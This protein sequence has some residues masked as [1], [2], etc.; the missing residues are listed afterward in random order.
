MLVESVGSPRE[1]DQ[2]ATLRSAGGGGDFRLAATLP[3]YPAIEP[4]ELLE[5]AGRT[6]PRP[7]SDY[8]RYLER[9]GAWGTLDVRSLRV[10]PG[11]EGPGRAL[12]RIRRAAGEALAA[13]LPE[14][15]AGLAAGIMVGLRD[16]V[17]REL[18]AAF[19]TAG[20]SHVVAI[21]GWNI[22]IVA[23]GIGALTGRLGRRRRSVVTVLAI[24]I[25][26]LFAGASAS[27]LRAAVMAGVVLLARETGRAGRAAAALGWA[28]AIL[29][30][31]EPALV[32]DAGFQLSTLA[33]GG[34]IAWANPLTDRLDRWTGG[35]MPRWLAENLGVSLA[36]QAATLPLV[37][38]SF[39]RLSLIA[40]AVNLLV[41]PIVAPTMAAA[42][43][44]LG[45]GLAIGLGMPVAIGAILAAPAWVALRSIVG[46]VH[47]AAAVPFASIAVEEGSGPLIG[48]AMVALGVI[49]WQAPRHLP[50]TAVRPRASPPQRVSPVRAN[51]GSRA[52]RRAG[53]TG[54]G[55]WLVR[56]TSV[57]LVT[58]VAVTAAVV[59]HRPAGAA[60]ITVLDVG[61]GDAILIEGSRGGRIL[62][63]GGP[64][65]GRLLIDLDGRIPPWDRRLDAVILSH[66]HEDHVAGLARLLERYRV[67]RVFETGMLGPGP[68]YAAW[69]TTLGRAGAPSR[70]TLAAGDSLQVDDI[71]MRVL[72]PIRGS[73]PVRPTDGG[74]GINNVSIVLLGAIGSRR[75]L[76]T[77]DVEEGVDPA[78]LTEGLPRVDVLKVAHHGS[79]T[80]TTQAFVDAV[81]PRIAIASAGADNPYGHP[82]RTT[83]QRL[84]A[85]GAR[86]YRTDVDGTVAIT[87]GPTGPSVET[88]PRKAAMAGSEGRLPSLV[89]ASTAAFTTVPTTA[90]STKARALVTFTCA[91][92]PFGTS[93]PT[94]VTPPPPDRSAVQGSLAARTGRARAVGYHR[95]DDR[96]LARG[97][98]APAVLPGSACLVRGARARRGRSRG[99]AGPQDGGRGRPCRP[100]GRRDRGAAARC[101][102]DRS[103]RGSGPGPPARPWIGRL[104]DPAGP[105]GAR[106]SGR[107]P[108]GDAPGR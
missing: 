67:R 60:R 46:I 81:R 69:L 80:A 36:A 102:Q 104:A 82:A 41:V 61:Q 65:P 19:T 6:R 70:A 8:G 98:G 40:P 62:I 54:R 45:A 85:A 18:A 28:A 66:P 43:V 76:L 55:G 71:A 31:V 37:L 7:D 89:T 90:I 84:G 47:F 77:G 96:A 21:S 15:E 34:L 24:T 107:L 42:A 108:P 23:A 17:D 68:G 35:R 103:F 56:A 74:T 49:A 12:E 52:T 1:G 53:S 87:F 26:V 93:R 97:G 72:W 9:L 29:L 30:V 64:D 99:L 4:G 57:A 105:S 39:G 94:R 79:R 63:D 11:E 44:A 27:V 38:A 75:F 51:S 92:L 16:R 2:V 33:T 13:V 50:H 20:V 59:V 78:L 95:R 100:C 22:A 106:P 48:L 91:I 3:A 83:L 25:Y 14:P 101:R 58:S 10:L 88:E 32:A 5:V 73:V 86:V